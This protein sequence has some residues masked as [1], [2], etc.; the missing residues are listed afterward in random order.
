MAMANPMA[1]FLQLFFKTCI[2]FKAEGAIAVA[3]NNRRPQSQKT[4]ENASKNSS[5][6]NSP[7]QTVFGRKFEQAVPL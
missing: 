2:S 3:Y 6:S 4:L 5:S 1:V 7:L